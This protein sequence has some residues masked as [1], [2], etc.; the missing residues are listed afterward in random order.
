MSNS[1]QPR[2]ALEPRYEWEK[3]LA[4][5]AQDLLEL[6]GDTHLFRRSVTGTVYRARS[7][8]NLDDWKGELS[9]L[10]HHSSG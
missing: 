4:Y 8:V 6:L 3:G 1:S 5:K 2:E 7:A 10:E 9:F